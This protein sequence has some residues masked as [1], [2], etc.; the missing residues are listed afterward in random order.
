MAIADTQ[1]YI[2]Q[3]EMS[4]EERSLYPTVVMTRWYQKQ[5]AN[6]F[7]KEQ[8]KEDLENEFS[9]FIHKPHKDLQ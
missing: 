4:G 8:L 3:V 1:N 7:R 6:L 9:D 5:L 2:K